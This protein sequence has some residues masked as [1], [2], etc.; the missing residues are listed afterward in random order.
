MKSKAL[1][2]LVLILM[3]CTGS[4]LADARH[5]FLVENISW[6]LQFYKHPNTTYDEF[7]LNGDYTDAEWTAAAKEVIAR[8]KA[9]GTWPSFFSD[10]LSIPVH[11]AS[12]A[13]L[14]DG[15]ASIALLTGVAAVSTAGFIIA[16][17][18]RAA[19]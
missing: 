2:A 12:T 16:R 1:I 14:G 11:A 3:L 6:H 19:C 10:D 8:A 17:R 5:D 18:K 15:S 13:E 9:N 4:A 7:V